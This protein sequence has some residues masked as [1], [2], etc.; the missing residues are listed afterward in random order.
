MSEKWARLVSAKIMFKTESRKD[1]LSG[2]QGIR[3]VSKSCGRVCSAI[4]L[5]TLAMTFFF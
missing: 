2:E 1:D 5:L 3:A 4:V